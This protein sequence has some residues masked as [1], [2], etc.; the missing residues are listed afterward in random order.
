MEVFEKK[1]SP[2]VEAK[3]KKKNVKTKNFTN[4]RSLKKK[5]Y[6]TLTSMPP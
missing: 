3:K 2:A 5:N 4:L 6:M 1:T